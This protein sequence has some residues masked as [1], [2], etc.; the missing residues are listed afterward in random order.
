MISQPLIILILIPSVL[1][2]EFILLIIDT[3]LLYQF[4]KEKKASH[5]AN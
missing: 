3:I 1:G 2:I 5:P 4:K